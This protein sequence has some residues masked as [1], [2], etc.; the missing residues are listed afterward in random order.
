[1]FDHTSSGVCVPEGQAVEALPTAI[2][3][4]GL[5]VAAMDVQQV[6]HTAVVRPLEEVY[7]LRYQRPKLRNL[8]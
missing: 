7:P 8:P 2:V 4:H 6:L 5:L 1:M 3:H